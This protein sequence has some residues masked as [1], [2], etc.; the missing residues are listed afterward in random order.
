MFRQL[1]QRHRPA[2]AFLA[3]ELILRQFRRS[4]M[5]QRHQLAQVAVPLHIRSQQHHRHALRISIFVFRVSSFEM[6]NAKFDVNHHSHNRLDSC[7]CRRLIKRHR[8]IQPIRIRQRHGRH[9]LL[10]RRRNH[11]FRRRH[12]PQKRIVAVTMQ[13]YEHES[14][15]PRGKKP[16]PTARQAFCFLKS[17]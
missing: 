8:R 11:F 2:V 13:M 12:A 17:G 1:L 9:L 3:G 15:D 5:P 7:R 4:Q 14:P 10:H 6:R 16:M